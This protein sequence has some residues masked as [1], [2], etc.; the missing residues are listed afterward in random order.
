MGYFDNLRAKLSTP[1]APPANN[2][3]TQNTPAKVDPNQQQQSQLPG[4]GSQ[5]TGTPTQPLDPFA[6]YQ[7]LYTASNENSTEAPSFKLD[8]E[9]LKGVV[10]AQDFAKDLPPELLQKAMSGDAT[11]FMQ[12]LNHVGRNA[13]KSSL[14]HGSTLTDKFVGATREYDSKG[15]GSKIRDQN[16]SDSL[17]SIPGYS[18]P[19]AQ[20]ELSRVAK[21]LAQKHPDAPAADIA[22]EARRYLATLGDN[23][24]PESKTNQQQKAKASEVDW[25]SFMSSD[26]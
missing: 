10:D 23:L 25:D 2:Q 21:L 26:N 8:G 6:A 24:N 20:Q 15:L 3:G 12:A 5:A 1:A 18:N 14:E 9:K 22:A 11:A 13:Y 19:V 4:N 7:D 16:V 17:A